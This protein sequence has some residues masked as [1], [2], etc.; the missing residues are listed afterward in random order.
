MAASSGD[1]IPTQLGT[2]L[3]REIARIRKTD[4]T[5]PRVSVID[6]VQAI[7]GKDARHAPEDVRGLCSSDPEVDGISVHFPGRRQR[8]THVAD[9]LWAARAKFEPFCQNAPECDGCL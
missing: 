5:P 1:D 9:V 3:G 2:L 8:Y 6:V 7:T 4:Q